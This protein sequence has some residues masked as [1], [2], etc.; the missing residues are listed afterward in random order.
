MPVDVSETDSVLWLAA[1]L[2]QVQTRDVKAMTML[3]QVKHSGRY[4]REAHYPFTELQLLNVFMLLIYFPSSRR[5]CVA[6]G[7]LSGSVQLIFLVLFV[8]GQRQQ[9]KV[10]KREGGARK[11]GWQGLWLSQIWRTRGPHLLIRNAAVQC[12]TRPVDPVSVECGG[13]LS[14]AS[15]IL[16]LLRHPEVK[17]DW[18]AGHP[19]TVP[20][21]CMRSQ[22]AIIP[23]KVLSPSQQM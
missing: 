14:K 6:V 22:A 20:M 2:L 4:M 9:S 11:S 10:G 19:Q 13:L 15:K 12:H 1:V 3:L 5:T 23:P 8:T 7:Q 16:V 17:P 18:L 21:G